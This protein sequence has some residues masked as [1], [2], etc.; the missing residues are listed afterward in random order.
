MHK[1]NYILIIVILLSFTGW[2][3]YAGDI[4]KSKAIKIKAGLLYNTIKMTTWPESSFINSE[5]ITILFLGKDHNKLGS[6]FE[7]QVRSRSLTAKGRKLA[8]KQLTRTELDDVV[9]EELKQCHI[10]FI[11]SSYKGPVMELLLAI[12]NRPVLL[13]GESSSFPKEGGMISFSIEKKHVSISVNLDAI[14]KTDLKISAQFL[15]HATIVNGSK[16][17][18]H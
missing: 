5:P 18:R 16:H 3:A 13:V 7:S 11:M 8:V 1:K 4:D 9:R 17:T 15:Q 14:K 2:N 12:G 6:Y 10:L